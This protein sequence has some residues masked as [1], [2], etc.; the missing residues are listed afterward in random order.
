VHVDAQT[1][2]IALGAWL[3]IVLV[4]GLWRSRGESAPD[5]IRASGPLDQL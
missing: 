4:H 5:P 3:A 1:A 2:W